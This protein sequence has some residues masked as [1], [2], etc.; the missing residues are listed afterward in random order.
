MYSTAVKIWR[1][2]RFL[3]TVILFGQF[4]GATAGAMTIPLKR[5]WAAVADHRATPAY[6]WQNDP[7]AM[8]ALNL[9]G[10]TTNFCVPAAIAT[11][12]INQYA[13]ESPGASRLPLKGLVREGEQESIRTHELLIDVARRCGS[14]PVEG[15]TFDK[16]VSCAAAIYREAGYAQAKVRIIRAAS[17]PLA[18]PG[19]EHDNRLATLDDVQLALAQ[20]YQV[21]GSIAMIRR[22]ESTGTWSK[23]TSHSLNFVGL[24]PGSR[25]GVSQLYVTNPTRA[26]R[27]DG[28][29]PV[30]D[31]AT[32]ATV[33]AAIAATLPAQYSPLSV[34]GRLLTRP[35]SLTVLAGLLL[36]KAE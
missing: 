22:D 25:P 19:V 13:Y 31:I 24:Q 36:L 8:K 15:T 2:Q 12:L 34:E 29:S 33:D 11:A 4:N 28:T 17:Y 30:F 9:S 1:I 26:Y 35:N 3:A 14:D 5:E 6:V 10:N 20:G 21:I 27:V 7:E 23:V 18:G 16:A 32:L